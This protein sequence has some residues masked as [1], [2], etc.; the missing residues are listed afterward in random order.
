VLV[1]VLTPTRCGVHAV[2]VTGA[3]AALAALVALALPGIQHADGATSQGA[4]MIAV[5]I[6]LSG[7]TA[8]TV[9]A[10]PTPIGAARPI[11]LGILAVLLVGTVVSVASGG[12]Q[13]LPS[14][15]NERLTSTQSNRSAYWK[16]ALHTFADHPLNGV[17][18]GSFRVAWLKQRPFAETVR[19]AHSLYLETA[20]ELGLIGLVALIAFLAGAVLATR[21]GTPAATAALAAFALHAGLDWDWELPALSLLAILLLARL[22]AAQER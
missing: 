18:T 15:G 14:S 12:N 20:A 10:S 1:I 6:A 13:P 5:L 2:L 8:L 7:A 4:V 16:V 19:D 21:H 3:G 17:G 11:A 22:V 9:K